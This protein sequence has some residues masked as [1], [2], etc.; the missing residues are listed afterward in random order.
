MKQQDTNLNSWQVAAGW[1]LITALTIFGFVY[2]WY[3][4]YLLLDGLFSS[5]DAITLNKGAFY[6][7]GGAMLGCIL[8]YFGIN[9]LRGKAVTKAQ[10][11]TAS[12]GFFIGLGLIVI[13]PQL[14][15]HTT[16]NYLQ[17]NGYQICELQSRKWLHDK[18]MVYTHSAQHC[19]ELAIAD[20]TANPH[21]QKCQK[22]PMFKPTPPIS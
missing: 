5:A 2:F 21:R 15:H 20:C 19:L 17:A 18:V 11:K 12:Y 13:L 1:L 4:L 7:F 3:Y 9:K 16:E 6:C 10:N 14:I 8:L 22:L